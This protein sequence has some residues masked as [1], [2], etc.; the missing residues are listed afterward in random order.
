MGEQRTQPGIQRGTQL[1][2]CRIRRSGP[3]RITQLHRFAL[4][5]GSQGPDVVAMGD[6]AHRLDLSGSKAG[7]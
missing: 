3:D 4:S 6:G 1:V 7:S 2:H 5:N